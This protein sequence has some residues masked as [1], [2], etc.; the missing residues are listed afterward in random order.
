[1][2]DPIE[3]QFHPSKPKGTRSYGKR[4][5]VLAVAIAAP[6]MAAPEEWSAPDW[7]QWGPG[8]AG[9]ARAD[10]PSIAKMPFE[11]GGESFP[12]SAFYYL[13]D[14]PD[15]AYHLPN[16]DP[17]DAPDATEIA[18]F[19]TPIDAGPT[20]AAFNPGGSGIDK[21]RALKCMTQAIYY[22]AASE[23]QAGQKAVAQV[24]LNRVAHSAWP[25]SVC[26]V[27]FEG[28]N[29]RTGCQFSFTCDGSLRRK[30]GKNSWARAQSNA[31]RA[32][33]GEVYKPV[34]LATHYHTNWVNPYWA[35]SL[36]HI[37]TIGAHRFYKLR[38]K[39][40]R[41]G[42]FADR[43]TGSE[44]IPA[45]NLGSPAPA[46]PSDT[47]GASFDYSAGNS[48]ITS[49]PEMTESAGIGANSASASGGAAAAAAVPTANAGPTP[50]SPSSP[51]P[52]E[53][54][55]DETLQPESGQIR[56]EFRNSGQWINKPA[57]FTP[58]TPEG[59]E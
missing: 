10:S 46:L 19:G 54:F 53:N 2:A 11:V 8:P 28:S 1:M 50:T 18:E 15:V 41:S 22:E 27:V 7:S 21:A 38:G 48:A 24:V 23:S 47:A 31:A 55:V 59:S 29:R 36:D 26:G 42:A 9:L 43:Y 25:N 17:A 13:E 14:T 5:L 40:G 35:P 3:P 12:G 58:P 30:P 52:V 37:G 45:P 32:L 16:L 6:V 4:F 20:A 56:P 34:G 49:V 51:A 33:A 57:D 44:R 39:N